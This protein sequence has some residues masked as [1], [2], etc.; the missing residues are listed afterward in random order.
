MSPAQLEKLGD[1]FAKEP[2]CV[3]PFEFTERV[4]QDRI[5]VEKS[6]DYYAADE[7]NLD[8]ITYRIIV[9][10]NVRLSNLRSGDVHVAERLAPTDIASIQDDPDI[11]LA[12]A[13][14]LGYQGISVNIGNKNGLGRPHV[15]PDTPLAQN[16]ELREAFEMAIDREAIS[17]IVFDGQAVPDCSPISPVSPFAVEA[18]CSEF[19]PQAAKEIVDGTGMET[20]IPVELLV[21][22]DPEAVRLGEVIQSMA[23]EAGF[24]VKVRPTEFTAALEEQDAGNYEMFQVGWSGRIDPDQNIHIFQHSEGSLNTTGVDSPEI[25][26]LLEEARTI[27]DRDERKDIYQQVVEALNEERGIIYLYH[28]KLF[29]GATSDVVGIDYFGDGLVRV[30]RAGFS[31]NE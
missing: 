3:G 21:S 9:D 29:L 13:T 20:P 16:P 4:A 8:S 23:K 12:E 22:T 25:D 28:E 10:T 6:N 2:V 24:D 11:Q 7:V 27:Q 17:D 26:S 14:S 30:A 19:D 5:R 1:D 18:D 15:A 31:S